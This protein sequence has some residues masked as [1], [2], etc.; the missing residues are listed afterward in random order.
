ME[1]STPVSA[2]YTKVNKSQGIFSR[3]LGQWELQA[4]VVPGIIFILVFSYLPMYG[5]IMAFQNYQ[6]GDIPGFSPWVGLENFKDFFMND[7]FWLIIRNTFGISLYRLLFASTMPIILALLLNEVY[8]SSFKK[9]IQTISYL[10]HFVSWVVVAGLF[11]ELLSVDGGVVNEVLMKLHIYKEPVMYFGEPRF[12]WPILVISDVW[13]DVG[14]N[15][16]LFLAAIAAIDPELYQSAE[17]DGAGRFKK[18]WHVTLACIKPTI[19]VILILDVG[20]ILSVGFEQIMLLTNNFRNDMLVEAY[21]T[22][23]TYV[24]KMGVQ[25][26]RYSFAAAA[27]IFKSLLC[28]FL[29][30]LAN[31]FSKKI[32]EESLW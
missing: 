22:I 8:H 32:G 27:G 23:D 12:F 11:F 10:P 18:M 5:M 24:Y 6:L 31:T 16:I 28:V 25:L 26:S 13:K 29:L 1:S 4:M 9:A 7:N 15:S 20:G 17:I 14:W 30:T 21:E 2:R 19:A 3:L